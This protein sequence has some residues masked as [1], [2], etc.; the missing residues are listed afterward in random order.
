[1]EIWLYLDPNGIT[2]QQ[3]EA[4]W[5]ECCE[6]LQRFPVSL[7]TSFY[8]DKWGDERK[9]W[10]TQLVQRE[11]NEEYLCLEN[12][13]VSLAF[14]GRFRLYRNINHYKASKKHKD[15]L[16]ISE[17][18]IDS[19]SDQYRIWENGTRGSPYSLAVL[20]L[21]ILL[22]NRFPA[23]CMMY[24]FQYTEDQ[25]DNMCAWLSGVLGTEVSLPVCN[26]PEHLLERLMRLYPSADLI[27][28]RFCKLIQTSNRTAFEFLI[29]HG[30]GDALQNELIRQMSHYS[31]VSQWGVTGVLHPYL[32]ATQDVE[33]V[34]ILVKRVQEQ[35]PEDEFS[36]ERLLES[37]VSKGITIN[38]V[39]A[40]TVNEW[41]KTGEG[42]VT[43][44]E[45]FNRLFLGMSGLPS[46]ID[47]Y[48]SSELLLEIFACLEPV[49]GAKFKEII[50]KETQE[51]LKDY[52]KMDEV[53]DNMIEKA[54]KIEEDE[55]SNNLET[56]N[57]WVK[58]QYLPC[59]DYILQEVESQIDA[60][61]NP[62]EASLEI[63][64]KLGE[65]MKKIKDDDE[66]IKIS[67]SR[68][69]ILK[70]IS[71]FSGDSGFGLRETAWKVIDNEPDLNI[72]MMLNIYAS[73]RIREHTSWEWRKYIFETPM[74]WAT[75]RDMFLK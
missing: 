18:D 28:R 23:N 66:I 65:V 56:M 62:E 54:L 34:A 5:E 55:P 21:G 50:E 53:T 52:K 57:R 44:M 74:L 15:I 14:G 27:V 68:K 16:W 60:F 4:V 70:S 2:Q 61:P 24:G 45:S 10:T 59:E 39:H 8:E 33:K 30:H 72:L 20:A 3:W 11:D 69:K 19:F 12:D 37:L 43:T 42:L 29:E 1:M 46:R 17:E 35:N 64:K 47:F 7:A 22:E 26:D 40:E 32:E 41:N 75:M 51:C 36:L 58:R 31:S 25:I 73:L 71:F 9:V 49:N 13:M 48:I 67:S 6:V 38:P 63:A